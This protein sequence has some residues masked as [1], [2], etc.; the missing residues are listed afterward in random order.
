MHFQRTRFL[1]TCLLAS[2]FL[3]SGLIHSSPAKESPAS[4]TKICITKGWP[5]EQSD[6]Q[7][8]PS[9]IF[10]TLENGFRYVL[11]PNH[12]PKGRVAMYLNVQSGSLQ[13]TDKQRGLAH[14][15]E[16]MLFE[17]STHY[18]PGTLVEYFQSIG[19]E[20]GADTNAHTSYDETVYKL[21]LPNSQEKTLKDGLVVLGDYASGAL[22]LEREVDQ[23]RGIILAEKRTRDSAYRRIYK[24]SRE[25]GLVGTLVAER[26]IIGT[27]EVLKT[28]DSALLRQ[29]YETWYRPE[30]MILVAVGDADIAL[31]E[32]L[33]KKHFAGLQAK[34]PPPPCLDLGKVAESG[35][36]AI[37][38]FEEDLGSTEV[39]LES[40][41]N[42]A[43]PQPTKAEALLNLKQYVA[44]VMMYNRLQ[45]LVN[46]PKSPMTSAEFSSG[47]FLQ[48]LGYTSIEAKTSPDKWRQTLEAITTAQRQAQKFGFAAPELDR[49]K[50]QILISLQKEVQVADSRESDDLVYNII[51]ALNDNEVLLSPQQELDFFG[52]ALEKVTLDEV[53]QVF[54]EMWHPR[55]LVKVMG[56]TKLK[57]EGA[58]KPEDI[59]LKALDKAEQAELTD[60]VQDK[61]AVF[62]YL[63]MPEKQGKVADHTIYKDIKAE[64]YV[65]ANGL[66]LNL[67]QTDFEPN[68][69]RVTAV[70]GNGK[71]TE[72]KPGLAL[73]AQ[74]LLPESGFG[75]LTKEQLKE[76]LAPYSARVNFQV[77]EDSFQLQGKGLKNESELLFQ[78]LYTQLVDPA[79]REDAFARGMQRIHQAYARMESDVEGMMHLQGERFLAGGNLRYGVVPEE[80]LDKIT[81][82]DIE[83]WL[84]PVFQ[85]SAL[86]LSVVGDFDKEEIQQ[87]AGRYFGGQERKDFQQLD[88][89][90]I[91]FPSG[92]ALSLSIETHSEKGMVTVAWPTDDFWDIARTR[93]LNVLASVLGDRMRKLIREELGAAYSPY[94]YNRPSMVDPGYGVLRAVVVVDPKQADM[95]V[96]KLKQ[97][98]SQLANGKI[99]ADELERAVEPTLTSVRDTIR[100]NRY[101]MESVLMQS[102]WHPER[103]EWPKNILSDIA[104]ITVEE[105]SGLAKKY[106]HVDKAAEVILLP[107]KNSKKAEE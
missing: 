57:A 14:Y 30:N 8:D 49:A 94:A 42:V 78:L 17:G 70:L 11:M 98:G 72:T 52:P 41:W 10:G 24:V 20:F 86:E 29:Y 84:R 65:F 56:N 39:S 67:K 100:T 101:W 105:L 54:R 91:T 55:R 99:T 7:P 4:A 69:V 97:L 19:M 12:E 23:E 2:F 31:L 63:P 75:G 59:I 73:L 6:L 77:D 13:E 71:L 74:M 28:A 43:P 93:R 45:R 50:K 96:E 81:V 87:L 58:V 79:F 51:N 40:V 35:T 107:G 104:A 26:D 34:T 80:M 27:E 18:P 33:V 25:R 92:K 5:H 46:R 68:E 44:Q 1:L 32:K 22:L 3:V 21:M 38:L 53:N 83:Q 37:Y 60:W 90:Q 36:E 15:L 106:L 76:V 103:L 47:I 102:T 82:A 9:L 85:E 95:V 64:R 16:H 89:E 48:H 66:V 88:G 62:P 61:D